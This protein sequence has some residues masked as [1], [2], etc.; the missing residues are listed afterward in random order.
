MFTG[1]GNCY[2]LDAL[3]LASEHIQNQRHWAYETIERFRAILANPDFPCLFGR[4]AVAAGTCSIVFAR[5]GQL[6]ADIA[7]G[8]AEYVRALEPVPLKQ[9]IGNPLLVFLETHAGSSL[10]QQ[11][12]LAWSVLQELHEHD[13]LPWPEDIPKDPHDS[14]WSFCFAGMP[15]FINMNFPAH[16]QM[17]SRNLGE[18]IV[19]VINP[20]E[21]FDEVASATSESGQRI[22]ARIRERV[23]HYNDGVMPDTLGFFGQ[24]DNF[25]WRQYQL[26]EPGSLNPPR[27]PFQALATPDTLIEN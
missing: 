3:E 26:Q 11:Q 9:R 25:E 6:A 14:G 16:Q 2:R 1:Y 8:L 15:L 19:F 4:K 12:A 13:P 17:K 7:R 18:H 10:A 5:A 20:R 22:R 21:S 27:C 24:A 23:R